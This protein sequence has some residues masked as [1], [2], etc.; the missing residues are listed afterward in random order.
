MCFAEACI[1]E[2]A[3]SENATLVSGLGTVLRRI[4]QGCC[5]VGNIPALPLQAFLMLGIFTGLGL[6]LRRV[7]L[8]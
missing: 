5:R 6:R 3:R 1:G 7:Q 2:N 8:A 4:N